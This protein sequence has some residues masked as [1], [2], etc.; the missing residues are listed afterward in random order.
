MCAWPV[1]TGKRQSHFI[2][3]KVG[4]T[5]LVFFGAKASAEPFQC[6]KQIFF[7]P[8]CVWITDRLSGEQRRQNMHWREE[9]QGKRF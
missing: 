7:S 6:M 4:I 2:A 8:L 9:N 1:I 3:N 5:D